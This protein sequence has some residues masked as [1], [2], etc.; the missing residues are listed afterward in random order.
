MVNVLIPPTNERKRYS[1]DLEKKDEKE[2]FFVYT[3]AEIPYTNFK[4]NFN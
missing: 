4:N 3:A 1:K 2:F